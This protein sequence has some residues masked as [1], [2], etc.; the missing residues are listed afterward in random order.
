MTDLES[1]RARAERALAAEFEYSWI[2][3]RTAATEILALLDRLEAAE[4]E[5]AAY[6]N[7][8]D[9]WQ[10]RARKAEAA[11]GEAEA[12]LASISGSDLVAALEAAKRERD[13]T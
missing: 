4:E 7:Q 2:G 8:S 12:R 3:S 6:M 13:K 11:L 1:L 10:E 5:A 9:T